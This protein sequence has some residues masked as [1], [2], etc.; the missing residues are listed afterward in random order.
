[1]RKYYTR[2]CNFH[3]GNYARNLVKINKALPLAGNKNI[4]F[5]KLEIFQRKKGGSVKS[6]VYSIEEIKKLNKEIKNVVKNDLNNIT[7]KRKSICNFKFEIPIIM[8][9][10]NITPDSFSDGGL[11]F[12]EEKAYEQANLMI[13][14]GASIIDIGGESTRPGSKVVSDSEEWK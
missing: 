1:M 5:D 12:D 3:Y 14:G 13:A 10:L 7:N 11:F 6:S 2:P 4:C 9:V 8:G